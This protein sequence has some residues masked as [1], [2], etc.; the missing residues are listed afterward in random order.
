ML[1]D[2]PWHAYVLCLCECYSACFCNTALIL[3]K[4]LY[5]IQNIYG[6]I[7]TQLS[8]YQL[9]TFISHVSQLN[10]I[11]NSTF[12]NIQALHFILLY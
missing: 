3:S 7:K 12:A 1:H 10:P 9:V 5:T 6:Y 2:V 11:T 8:K 4:H